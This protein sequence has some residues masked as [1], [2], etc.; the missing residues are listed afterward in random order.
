MKSSGSLTGGILLVAGTAIGGGMLA[1]P[2]QT[3]LGGFIPSLAIY[4]ICW[5]F[6]ASTGLLFLE[7]S[8]WLPEGANIISMATATLGRF[9]KVYAWILYLFL[10]Y[11][12]TVAYLVGGG[13]L[14][15]DLSAS[16]LSA[17]GGPILFALLF[18]PPVIIGTRFLSPIN[19]FL[20]VAMG[21][22]YCT[23]LVIAF[24]HVNWE[25]LTRKCWSLS[26]ISLPVAFAA[27]AYQ[28]I[29]PTLVSYL[30]RDARR[31]RLSIL[32]GSTL[33]FLAYAIW[34]GLILGIIPVEGPGGLAEAFARG[35]NAVYPLHRFIDSPFLIAVSQLFAFLALLTS[36]FG[37]TLGLMDFL[38][39]G[40]GLPNR[41]WNKGLLALFVFGPPLLI[42]M[43]YPHIFLMALDAAG[44]FGCAL[45]LGL[46]PVTMAWVGRYRQGQ[47]GEH[48]LGGGKPLLLLLATFVVIEIACELCLVFGCFGSCH[49]S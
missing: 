32:V 47:K 29:I 4:V 45:L 39:D 10:F 27:F 28:G 14:L 21:L 30:G 12:L 41:G 25:L 35:E 7:V 46:L 1:L 8:L 48:Q 36:F 37:V 42:A 16:Y 2:V 9:G 6:M 11:C 22:L 20:V 23:F 15:S 24:P 17:S 44:G 31:I 26:L 38:A 5:L 19:G 40:T 33:P 43:A 49:P 3:A 13:N 18:A 34:E